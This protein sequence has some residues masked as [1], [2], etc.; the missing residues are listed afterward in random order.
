MYIFGYG[1]LLNS[2]SR[3]RTGQTGKPIP[4][5]V[6]GLTRYWSLI[7]DSY[8]LSPLAVNTGDGQVNGVLLNVNQK[9]LEEFDIREAGYQ[10]VKIP[11]QNIK[12]FAYFDQ[13]EDVWVYITNNIKAPT[14]SSPI[15]QSYVDTV[16]Y[17]CL[18]ISENFAEHFIKYTLG[19]EHPIENDRH[20]PKYSRSTNLTE[21]NHLVIDG[22]LNQFLI[23]NST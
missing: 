5:I 6:H 18:E 15:V 3:E 8:V 2:T 7:D 12:T 19:W 21:E 9:T 4:A 16:I 14:I 10:R 1:S 22:L 20:Q 11:I 23:C 13:S 17:G